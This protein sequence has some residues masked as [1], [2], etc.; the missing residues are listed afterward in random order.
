MRNRWKKW[1][2][3]AMAMILGMPGYGLSLKDIITKAED[4]SIVIH[5]ENEERHVQ[6]GET[7]SLLDGVSVEG[8]GEENYRAVVGD[9]QEQDSG[10][11]LYE[12][13]MEELVIPQDAA[14]KTYRVLYKAQ[15]SIDNEVWNDVEGSEKEAVRVKK[16]L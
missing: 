1:C 13:G 9:V 3:V 10:I 4:E 15:S 8:S 16:V 7:V 2:A 6:A 14:G 11:S 12:E 5:V